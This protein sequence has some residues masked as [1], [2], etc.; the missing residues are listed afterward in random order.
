MEHWC[1]A[2]GVILAL[3][4]TIDKTPYFGPMF[5]RRCYSF[6]ESQDAFSRSLVALTTRTEP[7]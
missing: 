4:S 1:T 3:G 5:A 7:A 2:H 6:L